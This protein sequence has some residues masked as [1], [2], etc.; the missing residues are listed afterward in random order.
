M[1]KVL[2]NNKRCNEFIIRTLFTIE[3]IKEK[4]IMMKNI[5]N[6]YMLNFFLLMSKNSLSL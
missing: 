4:V 5:K 3:K 1:K 6:S 2:G